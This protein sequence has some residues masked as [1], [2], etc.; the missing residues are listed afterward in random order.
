MPYH[1]QTYPPPAQNYGG[2][3]S[4]PSI[5]SVVLPEVS[6]L[7]LASPPVPVKVPLNAQALPSNTRSS[8]YEPSPLVSPLASTV[9]LVSTS[10]TVPDMSPE[11][12]VR[13]RR[14]ALM[15]AVIGDG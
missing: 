2:Y 10:S 15:R 9:S 12:M 14:K 5:S 4:I 7:S 6:N 8:M 11:A 13:R 3:T 1:A